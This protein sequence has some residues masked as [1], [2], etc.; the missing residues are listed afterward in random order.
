MQWY[1]NANARLL[2]RF[3]EFNLV[4]ILSRRGNHAQDVDELF[5]HYNKSISIYKRNFTRYL[6]ST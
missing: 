1:L 4:N 3:P 5:W 6:V 2:L